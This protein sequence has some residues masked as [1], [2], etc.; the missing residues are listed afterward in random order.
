[1]YLEEFLEHYAKTECSQLYRMAKRGDGKMSSAVLALLKKH[2][3]EK[4]TIDQFQSSM[5]DKVDE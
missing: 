4:K 3:A 1:M 5:S 2:G